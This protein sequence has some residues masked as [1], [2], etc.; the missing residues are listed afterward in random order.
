MSLALGAVKLL[1]LFLAGLG[2]LLY[3]FQDRMIFFPQKFVGTG[4]ERFRSREF[5]VSGRE[6]FL[7]GW[8]VRMTAVSREH[9]LLVYYGGNAEEVSCNLDDLDWI[10]AGAFLYMNY[11]GY[12]K[13]GGKPGEQA[14]CRDALLVLDRVLAE[15]SLDPSHVLLMGRSLGSGVACFVASRRPV[16]GVILVTPFDSLTAVAR[17]YYPFLPVGLLLRHRF[18]SLSLAPSLTAPLLSL[19]AEN[20]EIIPMDRSQALAR[21]WGG[22]VTSVVVPGAG[23]NDI[24]L[25]N[26]YRQAV[27]RFIRGPFQGGSHKEIGSVE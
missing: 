22:P 21:A 24:H 14:L 26:R 12:G 9:P 18:D 27:N 19:V 17:H 7:H 23:H 2:F 10:Q 5:T 3:L 25:S 16:G 15:E 11:R 1:V 13:S 20:D 6:A 4:P 8:L